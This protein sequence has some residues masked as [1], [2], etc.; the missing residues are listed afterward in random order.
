MTI[1]ISRYCI[2]WTPFRKRLEDSIVMLASTAAV[3]HEADPPFNVEGDLSFRS[4]AGDAA[5]SALRIADAHY[6][7]DCVDVDVNTVFPLDRLR[8]LVTAG[9]IKAVAE[10]HFTTGFTQELR[11]F[12]E[13][14]V[15]VVAA[16]MTK[17]RPDCVVL[18]GG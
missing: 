17:L 6:P 18:T 7:H 4:I 8:E 13:E 12:K 5:M 1:E 16:E 10:R 11:R 2:P 14:T 15:P 3:H 9:T